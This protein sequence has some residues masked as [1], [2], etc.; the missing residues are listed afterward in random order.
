MRMPFGVSLP[1]INALFQQQ[2]AYSMCVCC[3]VVLGLLF[4]WLEIGAHSI[5]HK[6][7]FVLPANL[8][9][10]FHAHTFKH[11]QTHTKRNGTKEAIESVQYEFIPF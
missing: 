1:K 5:A 9:C 8:V 11:T 3:S 6:F 2:L 4:Q 10:N 7:G